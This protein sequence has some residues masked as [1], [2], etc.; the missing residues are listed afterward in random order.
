MRHGHNLNRPCIR[1]ESQP[2]KL[3]QEPRVTLQHPARNGTKIHIAAACGGRLAQR[4][5][6]ANFA[7]DERFGRA[8]LSLRAH[9][10]QKPLMIRIQQ[11]SA[12]SQH[13]RWAGLACP[14]AHGH[15]HWFILHKGKITQRRTCL[16]RHGQRAP[17]NITRIGA[18]RKQTSHASPRSHNHRG[19]DVSNFVGTRRFHERYA[20]HPHPI[21]EQAYADSGDEAYAMGLEPG[22]QAGLHLRADEAGGLA[23]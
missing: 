10:E 8:C 13:G 9:F 2:F 23:Q 22:H 12:L 19:I 18:A 17:I 5:L 3:T 20:I 6:L 16:I 21:R 11:I 14:V 4:L 1:I 7:D 15:D